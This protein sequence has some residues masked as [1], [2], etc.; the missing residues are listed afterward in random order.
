MAKGWAERIAVRAQLDA[1]VG[2]Q[3]VTFGTGPD[4][5]TRPSGYSHIGGWN[6]GNFG[7][8][9]IDAAAHLPDWCQPG[10]DTASWANAV[11]APA[12][13]GAPVNHIAPL[14]R[15]GERIP[16]KEIIPLADGRYE[17]D[18]G[19]N[20]TGWLHLKF[21]QLKAGQLVR[22]HFADRLF[23]DGVQASPI[24]NIA[25]SGQLRLVSPQGG[26][27][28][29]YQTYK[30]TSEFVS[31]GV[32]G[33][34][35]RH[36]FN[37]AGF[38]H[39]VVEGLDTAPRKEDATALLVESALPDAGSFE[40]SDPLHQPDPP[41]EPLD[42]AL[43]EPRRL[44]RRLPAPR[45]HGLRRRPGRAAG[46]DDE[47]RCR[48]LLCKVG[49]RLAAGAE[50]RG[51]RHALH[52]A[53]L[54]SERRR[55]ALARG[56]RALPWQHYLHYG[57]PRCWRTTSPPPDATANT[58]TRAR[59]TMSCAP[60][61]AASL[62]SATGC[63]PAAAWTP[64]TGPPARWRSCSATATASISG[65]WWRNMAAALGRADE[66]EHARQRVAAIRPAVH[67]AFYD[68][69]NKRY[70]I[71]EQIYYALPLLIGVTPESE[72]PAVMANL[73][74]CIVEKNKGHLDTGM[75][76]TMF[77]LRFLSD[78]GRDDLVLAI[79]QKKDYPGWGY[80]VEQG[81]T[82]LWEQWNGYWSQIHSCFT[83]AD[84]WL[85]QG[86]AGIRPD[87]AQPGFKNVIIQ[88]AVVGDIT[89]VKGTTIALRPHRQQLETRGRQADDGSTIPPNT[90]ATVH[91]P[92]RR[93]PP[94]VD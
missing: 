78:A 14:N 46:H 49:A 19:T 58:S 65:N 74:K 15:I 55:P 30:Q 28:N 6:W 52:R 9:R 64:A 69:A 88:P 45:A 36:K 8:E 92:G 31:A 91:V 10:L 11:E 61:A 63:R 50:S 32:P 43:P 29:L 21:P 40:C 80:M 73:V 26:G 67:A 20:L 33:E 85:Y 90:T 89:W 86:L 4:W 1:V 18:F 5:K 53:A 24:G 12:P 47:F 77:L 87:P 7:G 34:E 93:A 82:T 83:S 81:A 56:D 2:G 35:F 70:V 76:G 59:P 23:P 79:Y 3:K 44:L 75:L 48:Q 25:I 13:Q 54:Y 41:G 62:S 51:R 39:V 37:Y 60:G 72:R 27:H 94:R 38:R 71:D 22:M 57:D 84:N 42:P 16:A 17:I 68:A 66:A